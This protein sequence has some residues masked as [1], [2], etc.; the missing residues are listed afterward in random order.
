MCIFG[1]LQPEPSKTLPPHIC[2]S[3][4][5]P[6]S[7]Q[8]LSLHPDQT[9]IA[10]ETEKRCR[11]AE[12]GTGS[13]VLGPQATLPQLAQS[14]LWRPSRKSLREEV[15]RKESRGGGRKEKDHR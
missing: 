5:T 14:G 7:P 8:P 3:P 15:W 10:R 1:P 13:S 2:V 12:L 11:L 4:E 9:A 6:P